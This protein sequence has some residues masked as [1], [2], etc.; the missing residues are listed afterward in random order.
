MLAFALGIT[1]Q[2]LWQ[3]LSPAVALVLWLVLVFTLRDFFLETRYT[4]S[5]E[6]VR[7]EGQGRPARCYPWERFRAYVEDR[8]GLFLTPY[9]KRR[10]SEAQRG[11]FLP[12]KPEQ[13]R[14]SVTFCQQY[15][16]DRREK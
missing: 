13:R 12:L 5:P 11:V 2:A 7:I 9:R 16:L 15:G 4:L 8:N 14:Q 3:W 6:G 1:L 10:A